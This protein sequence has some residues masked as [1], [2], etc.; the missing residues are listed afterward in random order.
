M[1]WELFWNNNSNKQKGAL[2]HCWTYSGGSCLLSAAQSKAKI[3]PEVETWLVCP[4]TWHRFLILTLYVHVN[5]EAT[6]C[7]CLSLCSILCV[8]VFVCVLLRVMQ[9]TSE[10]F[11]LAASQLPWI[12]IRVAL[13]TVLMHI[14]RNFCDEDFTINTMIFDT[15]L[16]V[17]DSCAVSFNKTT[18]KTDI[19]LK[20]KSNIVSIVLKTVCEYTC[21]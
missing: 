20:T 19:Y 2:I 14:N 7:C 18:L 21:V 15:E 8:R 5:S 13:F 11:P 4:W 10:A 3:H 9:L 17:Y 12:H 1:S 6:S 16:Q